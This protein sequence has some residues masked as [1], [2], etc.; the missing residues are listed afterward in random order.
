MSAPPTGDPRG[1]ATVP[2][3]TLTRAVIAKTLDELRVLQRELRGKSVNERR[4]LTGRALKVYRH[5]LMQVRRCVC[6]WGGGV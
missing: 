3:R 2:I 5:R 4:L 1:E 6:V